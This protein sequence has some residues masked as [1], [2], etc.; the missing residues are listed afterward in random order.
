M[1][2]LA[3][4]IEASAFKRLTLPAGRV[5]ARELPRYKQFLKLETA[6]L[7]MLHRA[8]GSGRE[9]CRA[10]A[11]VLDALHRHILE[12]L[13]N[14]LPADARASLPRYALAAIGGYGR[15]EL[16]P[17]SD[18]DIMLLH[19]GDSAAA[20]RGRVH[21]FI[22]L[23]TEPDGLL[24]TLFDLG[25]KVGYSVRTLDDC[26]TAA[27]ENIQTKT[28]L[29]EARLLCGDEALFR[30]MQAVVLARCV[31]GHEEIYIAARLADQESR[32]QKY[33]N[34]VLMQE[35]NIKN[36]CGGLRDYQNLLWM[37]YFTKDRPRSLADL[38]AKEYINAAERRQLDAAYDYLLRARNEL[39]YHTNRAGDV[40]SKSVQP[41]VAHN[42]GYP[43]RSPSRRLEQFMRDYY[44]HA[45]NIDMI[46]RTVERRLALL[47]KPV[48]MPFLKKFLPGRRKPPDPE[49]DGFRLVEGE[50]RHLSPR[51]FREDPSRLMRVFLYAQQRGA[52]LHPDTAQLLR[53]ELRLVDS[54]FLRNDH[55]HE[56]FREILGQR[57]N[58]AAALRAMHEVDF[59][60]KY[61]PE[62]GK[63]TCLVQHEFFHIYT[64]DE[65]TLMCLQKLDDI[66]AG[67]VPNATPYQELFQKIER[68][69]ILYLALL[70]HDSGKAVRGKRHELD[71]AQLAE[72]VA[73]R[74]RLDGAT[75]HIL[76][77]L[78][79]H[80][81]AIIQISQRRDLDDPAVVR[82]FAGLVQTPDNLNKLT[83]HTLA[84]SLGTSDKLWNSFKDMLL[85]TLHRKTLAE[86][87]GA[88]IFIRVEEK[89]RELLFDEV[90]RLL[91]REVQLGE[92]QAHFGTLP[93]RYFLI[94]TAP[95]IIA[96]LALTNRFMRNLLGNDPDVSLAPAIEW[97]DEPDRGCSRVKICT[98][99]RAGLFSK[100][101]GSFTAAGL[102]ILS[103]Q[104]FTRADRVVLDTFDVTSARTGVLAAKEEQ[105]K[106]DQLLSKALVG[107]VDFDPLIAKQKVANPL[108]QSLEGERI[109]TEIVFD[110][111]TSGRCTVIDVETEDR[112]GLLYT[113]SQTMSELGLDISIAKISTE[114]GAAMDSFY[115]TELNGE[116][117][118][119]PHR[120]HTIE[121]RLRT[122]LL[123]FDQRA[124]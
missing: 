36:G 84:D 79:E 55:V 88:T 76:R 96:D 85:W 120:Q 11:V 82:H 116:K 105:E 91:P 7:K 72:R 24:Y 63:L 51:V 98:W 59:L 62:F 83:L 3:D 15:G 114:K 92:A 66:W 67:R 121:A 93:P 113:L 27:N 4:K 58:V 115:V 40:L 37:A 14:T 74:L 78:V 44:L 49:V 123:N 95:E 38:Q 26:V 46:T 23:L 108:Y 57:G 28:S 117:I 19:T 77:L 90:V 124:K 12:S 30:E 20:A 107:H 103:A 89:Q 54:D 39:H 101:A 17:H 9:V 99:D 45:R 100:L 6:R 29:I 16:N 75:T 111:E 50:L 80:H 8:G 53:Q 34:S 42:L 110:N 122:A 21:P 52:K 118:T 94:H 48:R 109:A 18:I 33:G 73:H 65:H 1:P 64:A 119:A 32:R 87:T 10:R 13:V 112:V 106:F 22:R 68:P 31:R 56:S 2:S 69:F 81:L 61:L 86:L 41:A 60:G 47:P 25:L 43:D 102:N 5:P 35:P 70:L 71:S 97:T 104:I